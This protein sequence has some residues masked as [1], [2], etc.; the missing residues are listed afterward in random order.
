MRVSVCLTRIHTCVP[1]SSAFSSGC[2]VNILMPASQ[3]PARPMGGPT[4]LSAWA[5]SVNAVPKRL[6]ETNIYMLCCYLGR[7][8]QQTRFFSG[9][10]GEGNGLLSKAQPSQKW[11]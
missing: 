3:Q 9:V 1:I 10:R 2:S 5:P 4:T 8:L 6:R 11:A 7:L